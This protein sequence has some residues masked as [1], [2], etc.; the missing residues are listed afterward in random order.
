MQ[1]HENTNTGKRFLLSIGVTCAILIAEVIGG[2][3]TGSLALPRTRRTS[4]WT[5]S[6]SS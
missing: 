1:A 6:P 3:W 2:Y 5:S 4:S